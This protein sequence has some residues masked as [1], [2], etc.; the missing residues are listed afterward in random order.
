LTDGVP[1]HWRS[2]FQEQ[3]YTQTGKH[4]LKRNILKW[5]IS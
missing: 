4:C 5:H 2:L 3:R 1:R